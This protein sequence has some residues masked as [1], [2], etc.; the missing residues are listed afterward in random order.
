MNRVVSVAVVVTPWR[1]S[2]RQRL[3]DIETRMDSTE[4]LCGSQDT[5]LLYLEA[6][7]K[8]VL[9][10]FSSVGD[11]LKDKERDFKLA[12]LAFIAAFVHEF[13]DRAFAEATHVLEKA[14]TLLCDNNGVVVVGIFPT[15]GQHGT[16]PDAVLRLQATWAGGRVSYLLATA[17]KY[18]PESHQVFSDRVRRNKGDKGGGKGKGKDGISHPSLRGR[19]LLLTHRVR[20]PRLQPCWPFAVL[21]GLGL[22][23]VVFGIDVILTVL[24]LLFCAVG[25]VQPPPP[26]RT[27]VTWLG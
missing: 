14:E 9:R 10:G 4:A 5:R 27:C 13:R 26:P 20:M 11:F 7:I 21:F 24:F 17:G 18:L 8:V 22:R 23:F 25:P 6:Y 1:R 3:D 12:K 2:V 15:G 16:N 19:L